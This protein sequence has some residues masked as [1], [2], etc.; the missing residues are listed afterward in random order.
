MSFQPEQ[1][2]GQYR[3]L[4]RLG[5]GGMATV[6]HANHNE[7]GQEV[8]LKVLH[9]QWA[10]DETNRKRFELEASIGSKLNHPGIVPIYDYGIENERPFIV[11]KYMEGGNLAN[12]FARLRPVKLEVTAKLLIVM[13]RALDYAHDKGIIHR[14]L[15]LENI[16][17]D[18]KRRP[19]IGDFGIAKL[20]GTTRLTITGQFVGTPHYMAPETMDTH[21]DQLDKSVDMY[22]F[23]VMA[24]LMAT[25]Y[26]P[27]TATDP[28]Q[29][30]LKHKRE[31][32]PVPTSI[33]PDLPPRLNAV[34]LRG[35]QKNPIARYFTATEFAEA[36]TIALEDKGGNTTL[37]FMDK[38]NPGQGELVDAP[39]PTPAFISAEAKAAMGGLDTAIL[40]ETKDTFGGVDTT[41]FE[42]TEADNLITS[43]I[44]AS[45]VDSAESKAKNKPKKRRGWVA[46]LLLTLL[47][48]ISFALLQYREP[49]AEALAAVA[50]S[51]RKTIMLE[52][53]A[54]SKFDILAT[55][56]ASAVA[57]EVIMTAT[58]QSNEITID[59]AESTST[60]TPTPRPTNTVRP[61]S[62]ATIRPTNTATTR[63]TNTLTPS[64]TRTAT[65]RPTNTVRPSSTPTIRSSS[66]PVS[67]TNTQRPAPTNTPVP[68]VPT[69]VPI[70]PTAVP[71]VPT[72]VPIVPTAVPVVPTAVPIIPTA[73]PVVPTSVPV[74][75]TSAPIIPL[76]P[77]VVQIIPTVVCLLGCG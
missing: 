9:E 77:T 66:T 5:V 65:T 34:L 35:L 25:G 8:A 36:F 17:L 73:V 43:P 47:C 23:A 50:N 60:V 61:S 48:A 64:P 58:G 38:L 4:K 37:I 13:G 40:A 71:V 45:V 27:F 41:L 20:I 56:S 62:T 42:D 22:A 6:Y 16:M 31:K 63:P 24:Y 59:N 10:Y 19:A 26:F 49:I 2:F 67:P 72:S 30:V 76:V 57:D 52:N 39:N 70:I 14:D 15:K 51:G 68:I 18:G 54:L 74:Q 55:A 28:F 44:P 12:E 3:I 21:S 32:P 53:E 69:A 46:A 11:L 33:K 29:L 75:P 7:T 1:L